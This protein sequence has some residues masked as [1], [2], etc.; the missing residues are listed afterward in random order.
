MDQFSLCRYLQLSKIPF[1]ENF[2]MKRY[3]YV[4]ENSKFLLH[5]TTLV[6]NENDLPL[7]MECWFRNWRIVSVPA[8]GTHPIPDKNEKILIRMSGQV[9]EK[10]SGW[11][12]SKV[13]WVE[14]TDFDLKIY[15]D[16]KKKKIKTSLPLSRVKG[17]QTV[18]NKKLLKIK[19]IDSNYQLI[20]SQSNELK[21]WYRAISS[22][23]SFRGLVDER[24]KPMKKIL[25]SSP[26]I[27]SPILYN[28]LKSQKFNKEMLAPIFNID[29][30]G[31][32]IKFL[33]SEIP[34]SKDLLI[35]L[36]GEFWDQK[37]GASQIKL[38]E[39][40]EI[41]KKIKEWEDPQLII[42]FLKRLSSYGEITLDVKIIQTWYEKLKNKIDK[43]N[44]FHVKTKS[45]TKTKSK[46]KSGSGYE[47]KSESKS[48]SESEY[49]TESESESEMESKSKGKKKNLKRI[50][51][52]ILKEIKRLDPR[53][54]LF[55]T[56]LKLESQTQ[57]QEQLVQNLKIEKIESDNSVGILKQQ[58]QNLEEEKFKLEKE[59]IKQVT[60]VKEE[61]GSIK[62]DKKKLK[63]QLSSLQNEL[64]Q[65]AEEIVT[66]KNKNENIEK[67]RKAQVREKRKKIRI[68]TQEY[69]QLQRK[70]SD[71]ERQYLLLVENFKRIK[72]INKNQKKKESLM[73]NEIEQKQS[74]IS[75]LKIKSNLNEKL[76]KEK[77]EENN[78]FKI[79]QNNFLK[80]L[81]LTVIKI[82]NNLKGNNNEEKEGKEGKE[83]KSEEDKENK[84]EEDKEDKEGQKEQ[85]KQEEK[86][87]EEK[88]N[89]NIKKNNGNEIKTN[90]KLW[91]LN[92]F[93]NRLL[94]L[95]KNINSTNEKLL[96]KRKKYKESKIKINNLNNS[97][98]EIKNSFE[99]LK[100]KN[101]N[102]EKEL[103]EKN[104]NLNSTNE[105]LKN[106]EENLKTIVKEKQKLQSNLDESHTMNENF[107]ILKKDYQDQI[108]L[109]KSND[110]NSVGL[111][112]EE[113][114]IIKEKLEE[115]LKENKDKL[116]LTEN[117]KNNLSEIKN[118]LE[119]EI[120]K[121]EHEI[122]NKQEIN[123]NLNIKN[124]KYENEIEKNKNNYKLINEKLLHNKKK[125]K[126]RKKKILEMEKNEQE[127]IIA[128]EK[129]NAQLQNDIKLLKQNKETEKILKI[130]ELENEIETLKQKLKYNY[131]DNNIT[132]HG[133]NHNK[134]HSS[135][136]Q[137]PILSLPID[138]KLISKN[139][140]TT[141]TG[142][143]TAT[144]PTSGSGSKTKHSQSKHKTNNF[145]QSKAHSNGQKNKSQK[146]N[147]T[148]Q[149][150]TELKTHKQSFLDA[151][152]ILK[153]IE[154]NIQALLLNTEDSEKSKYKQGFLVP[155]NLDNQEILNIIK[156]LYQLFA[157]ELSK[158]EYT[159]RD[160]FQSLKLSE[161]RSIKNLVNKK[162][163]YKL[164]KAEKIIA[165]DLFF[166]SI[167]LNQNNICKFITEL[168]ARK[169]HFAN[170]Y[171]QNSKLNDVQFSK[172][173]LKLLRI[174]PKNFVVQQAL[175]IQ[176]KFS[177]SFVYQ[178]DA[179]SKIVNPA[180]VI[181]ENAVSKIIKNFNHLQN[182]M[183]KL[184][185][186]DDEDD[187]DDDDD[188]DNTGNEDDEKKR[189]E[190]LELIKK[191]F[192]NARKD[193]ELSKILFNELF[194]SVEKILSLGLKLNN[195][196]KTIWSLIEVFVKTRK[197]RDFKDLQWI[198]NY[199]QNINNHKKLKKSWRMKVYAFWIWSLND[200]KFHQLFYSIAQNINFF[201]SYIIYDRDWYQKRIFN[202][203]TILEPLSSFHF[204]TFINYI[205]KDVKAQFKL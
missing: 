79:Q 113:I 173:L 23:I 112:I 54:I 22:V 17:L 85:E 144:T 142:T 138:I 93:E 24:L 49:E 124:K 171:S 18:T 162:K 201:K 97:F 122:N 128:F 44:N 166:F 108:E 164:S 71:K 172:R 67:K 187:D 159:V 189:L 35:L 127:K 16:T 53:M 176:E 190:N 26:D 45:K 199:Y 29:G 90:L 197:I 9:T 37:N 179:P 78:L 145:E 36:I 77:T 186:I 34:I 194:A 20:F 11:V 48:E 47:S 3:H 40:P 81:M 28:K 7:Q 118:N 133:H 150:K 59:N 88:N 131:E 8:Y 39:K 134:N 57:K 32:F 117:E 109:I 132:N 98:Y 137:S 154:Q 103:I 198:R 80:N 70:C 58:L 183:L 30:Q 123:E 149:P 62:L 60:K 111:K 185:N 152:T 91:K 120:K 66:L 56:M 181:I 143:T 99:E 115:E 195:K 19:S 95:V 63:K 65:S 102:Q 15:M 191:K 130:L 55:E 12:G 51:E 165:Q 84:S 126:E 161:I 148:I 114:R 50:D 203:S 146:Q 46:S 6:L 82:E 188:D 13:R 147:T 10:G 167:S 43:Q 73:F 83:D 121:F 196:N 175:D 135:I 184:S 33:L 116:N 107:N 14:L 41:K 76:L 75:N 1:D 87:K 89:E 94:F 177:S 139:K 104:N 140:N 42:T 86:E 72:Q 105:K 129:N 155:L 168:L 69:N 182:Q 100:I 64:S 31:I 136:K 163:L 170:W 157:Q 61:V 96:R 192:G 27:S 25:F 156:Y 101:E 151:S 106:T 160:V 2:K 178:I 21:I 174:L 193:Q 153:K 4:S 110:E 52:N 74:K 205:P 125:K 92:E 5:G 180:R 158:E 141:T 202:L 119:E 200:G 204:Q 68:L 38:F 169:D